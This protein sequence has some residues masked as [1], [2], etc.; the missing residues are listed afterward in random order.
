MQDQEAEA[1]LTVETAL[2]TTRSVRRKLD[3]TRPIARSELLRCIDVA[4]QA[5]V[6][7]A[8]ENW[9]F[10]IVTE[11][12][13]RDAIAEIYGA[14]L[15]E[16]M[17]ARGEVMP[18]KHAALTEN[19]R[20]M[21]AMIFVCALGSPRSAETAAQ[22]A[23]YGSILPAAWSLMVS[24]RANGIGSTWTTLLANREADVRELLGMPSDA[25]PTVMLPCAYMKGAVLRRA[26]RAPAR[27]VTYLD[28]W[29][30]PV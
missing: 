17:H 8:G 2:A 12:G 18:V 10:V 5:P 23:W 7:M 29:G 4:V 11:A 15:E 16:L 22:L 19:L 1:N 13:P 24:L 9:R 25:Q 27:S 14:I 26:D 20:S 6:S 21:P 28:V 3:L 30:S